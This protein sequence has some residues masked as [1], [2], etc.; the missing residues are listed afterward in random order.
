[1]IHFYKREVNLFLIKNDFLQ[2]ITKTATK[3]NSENGS[4]PHKGS[5]EVEP[6]LL[7]YCC[8]C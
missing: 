5:G 2:I 4:S 1:L 3:K 6:I 7:P 8:Y